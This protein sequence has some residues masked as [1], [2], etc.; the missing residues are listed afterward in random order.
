MIDYAKVEGWYEHVRK[1]SRMND[2]REVWEGRKIDE[3]FMNKQKC[4]S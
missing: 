3:R 4:W 2:Y 1:R